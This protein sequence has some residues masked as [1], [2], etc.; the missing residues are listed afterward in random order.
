MVFYG[1]SFIFVVYN[2]NVLNI[3][4]APNDSLNKPLQ[5]LDF[6]AGR[7]HYND[8]FFHA[9]LLCHILIDV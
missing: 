4:G 5:C 2:K 6:E 7:N 9:V 1:D 8:K 3:T